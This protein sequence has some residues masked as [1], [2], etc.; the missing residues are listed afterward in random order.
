MGVT[1]SC[2]AEDSEHK[3]IQI[4]SGDMIYK[5]LRLGSGSVALYTSLEAS[6]MKVTAWM[7]TVMPDPTKCRRCGLAMHARY[8]AAFYMPS[9][10]PLHSSRTNTNACILD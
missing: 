10:C 5:P 3:T 9:I 1:S 7:V 4:V 8:V 6:A 2:R